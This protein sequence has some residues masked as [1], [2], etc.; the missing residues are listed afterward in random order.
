MTTAPVL[1]GS[2][3]TSNNILGAD[4][5]LFG[6]DIAATGITEVYGILPAD[7]GDV[8]LT[9]GVGFFGTYDSSTIGAADIRLDD[10]DP[11]D[12]KWTLALWQ[13]VLTHEIGHAIGLGD[14]E[15]RPFWDTQA[16]V[17]GKV[18]N[19]S[20]AINHSD[21]NNTVGLT[22]LGTLGDAAFTDI[23]ILMETSGT[24]TGVLLG[25]DLAGRS[26][27]YPVPEPSTLATAAIGLLGFSLF[28]PRRKRAEASLQ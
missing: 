14:V 21:P 12:E 8:T 15:T 4:I 16:L 11:A 28:D 19:H 5:D 9:N 3:T 7:G 1:T 10:L 24:P 17:G 6:R 25:D 27:L 23:N 13:N 2:S 20:M 26:F 18:T 22:N